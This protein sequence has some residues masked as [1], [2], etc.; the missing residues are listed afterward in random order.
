MFNNIVMQIVIDCRL[1]TYFLQD[2]I[3]GLSRLG[4]FCKLVLSLDYNNFN[5]FLINPSS[6]FRVINKKETN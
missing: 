4:I 1:L 5:L 2:S 6:R 3:A